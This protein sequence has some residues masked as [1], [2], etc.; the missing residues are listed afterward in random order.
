[1]ICI[2]FTIS[3]FSLRNDLLCF[4]R[5]A[6]NDVVLKFYILTYVY[7]VKYY[8]R[9]SAFKSFYSLLF[10]EDVY[11]IIL[12]FLNS[13]KI[14]PINL[15][16]FLNLNILF[17]NICRACVDMSYVDIDSMLCR[18]LL[19]VPNLHGICTL[20]STSRL[21]HLCALSKL[22]SFSHW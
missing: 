10:Y 17:S 12:S 21:S 13:R 19:D 20:E 1:M 7:D 9:K 4:I 3:L 16:R 2:L 18:K 22:L 6:E 8:I 15:T 11:C 5:D 14:A